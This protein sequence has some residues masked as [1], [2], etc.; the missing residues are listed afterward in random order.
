MEITEN[1]DR[2]QAE[3]KKWNSEEKYRLIF[4]HS[5]LGL[6]LFDEKGIIV[7]CNDNFVKIIGSSRERLIGLN[8]LNLPDKNIVSTIH[9]ALNGSTGLYEGDYSSVTA[10]KITPVRCIF[11]PMGAGCRQVVGGVGIIEDITDHKKAMDDLRKSAERLRK[12]LEETVRAI[13]ALVEVRDPYTAGHQKRVADLVRA[14]AQE[15]KLPDDQI[16]GLCMAATVHDIGKISIPSEIL[17]KPTKLSDIEYELIK[18][19][20]KC[21]FDILKK[22]EFPWPVSQIIMEHHERM[23]GTGYP[24][25]LTGEKLLLESRILMVADVV[26]AMA[27]HRPHRSAFEI[28]EALDEII[29]NKG[30]LYD[31][32]V[33][34]V[35]LLLFQE[36]E[37]YLLNKK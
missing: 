28:S 26:E 9:K 2:K 34:D 35:C 19:H 15:M 23:N 36:K 25:K 1:T 31:A 17:S 13:V 5:P 33:V 3:E 21:G 16:E 7:T 24:N 14:I 32:T 12:A 10:K 6:L 30:I 11:E 8:M 20:C 22:V 29:R 18:S 37:Y 4:E 27:S